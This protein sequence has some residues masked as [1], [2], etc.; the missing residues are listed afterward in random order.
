MPRRTEAL[1][2][3]ATTTGGTGR[4]VRVLA[5]GL[6]DRGWRVTVCGPRPTEDQFGFT[7]SGAAFEPLDIGSRP[8]LSNASSIR[9]LRRLASTHDIVHAHSLRAG[10]IAG[11]ATPRSVPL[12]VTWHNAV[13]ASGRARRAYSVLERYVARRASSTLCVSGDLVERVRELGG[14]DV[15][16]APVSAPT[17]PEPSTTPDAVRAELGAL[18]RPLVVSVGRLHAQKGYPYLVAAAHLLAERD[19]APLFAIAGDGPD[20][21]TIEQQ[22]AA[23][24]GPVRLLGDR[25][26][27]PDLLRAADVMAL[28]SE[29]EGS[30]LV[31]SECLRAG[32]P[33]VGTAVGGVPDMVGDAGL[34]VPPRDPDAL[35]DAITA[36]LDSPEQAETLREAAHEAA[37]RLPTDESVVA[38]VVGTYARLLGE[39]V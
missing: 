1:I 8:S 12:V 26:D 33:F 2:S 17:L 22:I 36:V 37:A 13:L 39:P 18:D 16:L 31:V 23:T 29:W 34:L 28:A 27:I 9:T 11:V 5:A 32:V 3:I 35:A 25:A 4:H 19:P 20:R 15:H 6:V 24:G 10:A 7:G 30:P 21:A 14:R 38:D